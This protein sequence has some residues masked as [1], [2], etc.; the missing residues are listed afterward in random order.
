[1]SRDNSFIKGAAILGIAGIIVKILGAIY[2]IPLTNIIKAEGMG[3]YQTAYPFYTLMLTLSQA[4]FPV[5][6]AKLVSERRAIGD[7]KGSYKV[8][9]VALTGLII[10]GTL[11]SVFVFFGSSYIVETLGNSNAYYSLI[12]LAPALLVVPIMSAFRGLFQGRKNMAPTAISQIVEQLFRVIVG[13]SLAIVLLERGTPLAAGGASFGGS[14]GAI[15]GAIVVIYIYFRKRK[16]IHIEIENSIY[17]KEYTVNNIVKDL[18][19]IAIPITIG[20][21]VA[22]IMDTIDAGMVLQRLQDINYTEAQANDLYG[23]LKGMAQTLIN[24]P[25]VFSIAISMSLV[26]SISDAFSRRDRNTIRELVSTGIRFVLLIGL[27]CA[28]GLFV[29]STPI[30]DLLY[31]SETQEVI[32]STGEILAYLSFGV[33]FLTL[34]QALTAVLQGIGKPFVPVR[35]L[36]IGAVVKVMLTY[37]LT[38]VPSINVKGAAISTVAAYAIGSILDLKDVVKYTKIKL[39]YK[40]IIMKP[41]IASIGMAISAFLSYTLLAALI[42]SKYATIGAILIAMV[43]YAIMLFISGAIQY[44]DFLLL[45]KGE[46]IAKKLGRF[47]KR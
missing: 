41:L 37:S 1:M 4:G 42:G 24:L 3:Y 27:P 43:V 17:T 15:F 25:Q 36:I 8:F 18:L 21:A 40:T 14:A 34:I 11:S 10:G 6:I 12:A 7:Y 29:L 13:L 23:Q 22:P 44:D 33:I 32:Q 46:K 35:N 45:P 9:K 26:P 16:D 39:D 2:R 20:S 38:A 5:A 31:F 30:I 19:V 28:L 47:L